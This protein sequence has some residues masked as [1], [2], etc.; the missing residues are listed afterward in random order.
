MLIRSKTDKFLLMLLIGGVIVWFGGGIVRT[1][2][3]YDMFIPGTPDLKQFLTNAQI[4][5]SLRL[6]GLTATYTVFGYG[7]TLLGAIGL[8]ISMRRSLKRYGGVFMALVLFYICVPIEVY[9]TILDIRM[10]QALNSIPFDQLINGNT[11][12]PLFAERLVPW[13]REPV[14]MTFLA[15]M[16]SIVFLVWQPL[17]KKSESKG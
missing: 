9:V 13:V 3:V 4:N 8:T 1:A 14:F 12:H 16:T 10:L 6:Y 2:I 5:Y 15:Y 11:L 17:T 7:A